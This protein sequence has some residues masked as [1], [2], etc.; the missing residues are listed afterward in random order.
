MAV[1]EAANQ[2]TILVI[3]DNALNLKLVRDLIKIHKHRVVDAPNA[4]IG[5]ELARSHEPDLILMDIELPGISGIEATRRIR[6]DAKLK[7]IPVVA[8]SANAMQEDKDE[9]LAAGCN[10][11]ITKPLNIKAFPDMLNRYLPKK[12]LS[13]VPPPRP[14]NDHL[15]LVVDDDP[16]NIKLLAAQLLSKGYRVMTASDGEMALAKIEETPPDLI[17]L[18]IMMPGIDGYE[19]TRRLKT[20]PETK[21]IPIIL[22]TALTEDSE[23]K[24]GLEAG[25]DE[26]INKPV[27]YPELD[28]RVCSLLK[29][30]EYQDQIGSRKKSEHLMSQGTVK[31]ETG[32]R[33]K[34]NL[35]TVLVA[36][37][38]RT[39]AKL[40]TTYLSAI[41]CKIETAGTGAE[42]L[43]IISLKKIDIVLLDIMMP[44]LDGFE[45]CKSIKEKEETIPIQVVM[46]TGLTDTK[47]KLKGIELGT[48]DF[49]VKPVN[50]DELRARVNALIKKKAY[51]DRLRERVDGALVAAVTDKLTGVYN[52]GYLKRFIELEFKRSQR[53]N[54]HLA[55][56][57]VD[58][59][60]FK[61]F[62]DTHGHQCGDQALAIVAKTL[63]SNIRDIDLIARY[64]GEEFTIVLPYADLEAAEIIADRLL[65]SM[66]A[67]VAIPGAP[68]ARLSI[69]IGISVFPDS[70]ETSEALLETADASLYRAKRNGK[71]QYCVSM[72]VDTPPIP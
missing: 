11:Y 68:D 1:A 33:R 47:S 51:I 55:L 22:V 69:S 49:L 44:V 65:Q 16:L 60:D 5:F 8:L 2:S 52:H 58:V 25:A 38:D 43:R 29:L 54:H 19:V 61:R 17:L 64:G 42:A 40:M 70:C 28:A 36:E 20:N 72:A 37:D 9:A 46:I 15:I 71:N 10:D 34:A 66:S 3:E 21:E 62:N 30:K 35:P 23:K 39:S 26:F 31:Q 45:V 4:E 48:D 50:K 57:M 59:D 24:K 56:L 18:D 63:K 53:N 7:D 67:H 12:R 27:N 41:P 32:D 14:T 6:N 13:S